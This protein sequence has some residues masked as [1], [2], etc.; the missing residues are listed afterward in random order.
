MSISVGDALRPFTKPALI[1]LVGLIAF[2][3]GAWISG[4]F[5]SNA[6]PVQP[7]EFSHRIHAGENQIPCQYCHVYADKSA[8]AGVPSVYK[9][10]G[11]HRQ[12][13]GIAQVRNRPEIEKLTAFWENQEP[14]PWV[15]VHDVA[16]FVHFTHKRHVKAGIECQQCHGPVETMDRITRVAPLDMPWCVDCH[17]ENQVDDGLDCWTCHK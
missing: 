10:V 4:T 7:I 16:D 5:F 1:G 12:T 3:G 13:G 8:S 11:C 17:T 15:K 6:A 9:C 2:V 14:I